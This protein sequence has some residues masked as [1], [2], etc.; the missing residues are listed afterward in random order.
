MEG[1]LTGTLVEWSA[2][3]LSTSHVV[4]SWMELSLG[5]TSGFQST[6]GDMDNVWRQFWWIY[7]GEGCFWHL[8]GIG[9]GCCRTSYNAQEGPS[10]KE[11]E[12]ESR[13]VMSNSLRPHGL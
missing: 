2:S 6:A 13:S 11:S 9:Q 3:Y 1:V 5:W 10:V 12:S 4:V 8:E 7:L